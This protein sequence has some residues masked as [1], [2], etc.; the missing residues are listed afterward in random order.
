MKW[1][2]IVAKRIETAS[3]AVSGFLGLTGG[4]LIVKNLFADFF[5][6]DHVVM[7]L[8]MVLIAAAIFVTT[9]WVLTLMKKGCDN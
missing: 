1:N 6:A 4:S 8:L 9:T 3:N 2:C 7:G 5:N